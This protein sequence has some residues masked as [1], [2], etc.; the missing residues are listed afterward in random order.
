MNR[1]KVALFFLCGA[2]AFGNAGTTTAQQAEATSSTSQKLKLTVD[3]VVK[4]LEQRNLERA[5]ALRKFEATRT[6]RMEYRG[7]F[8][9]RDAEMTVSLVYTSPSDKQFVVLSQ[10]GTKFILDHIFKRLLQEERDAAN[11]ENRQRTALSSRNY[12]FTLADIEDSPNTPQYVLNVIPKTDNKYLYRGKIWVDAK[13]FAVTRIEAEP[14][15]SPSFWIKKSDIRHKYEKVD[16]FWLPAENKTESW[17]RLGGYALLTIEYNNY[18]LTDTAPIEASDKKLQTLP[19][20]DAR[21]V[22]N[23]LSRSLPSAQNPKQ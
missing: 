4:Q 9:N 12:D 22:K 15:K 1:W 2:L 11:E 21:L 14:A 3:Q 7:P 19:G 17:I 18:K 6:Y 10:S 16:N 20:A 13:D 8:G 5:T 23:E